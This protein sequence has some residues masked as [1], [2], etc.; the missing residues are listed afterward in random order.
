MNGW[1]LNRRTLVLAAM[2]AFL[3][4]CQVVPKAGP[5]PAPTV[6]NEPTAEALPTDDVR[7]RVAL[8]VP[9]TGSNGPVGQS[10]ANATTMALLDTNASGLRITTYDTATNAG[11]AASRA[12]QDGNMLILGPLMRENVGAV[13]A[14]ARSRSVPVISFSNDRSIA[15]NGVFVMGH[16][17]EQSIAR[18]V[19]FA[20]AK[21]ARTF[22]ALLP[23]GDYGERA[24]AALLQAVR[25][26]GGTVGTT[27]KY[28]R[29]N[30]SIV[31]A[32]QRLIAEGDADAVLVAEGVRLA[33]RAAGTLKNGDA[34]VQIIGTELWSGENS[35]ASAS[36]MSGAIFS[37]VSDAYYKGFADSYRARF[38]NAPY[39]I[40]TLGYDGVLLA[41][42]ISENWPKG[43]PF[44]VAQLLD[45]GGFLG[46]DGAFR[47][48][49]DGVIE[50]AMEVRQVGNATITVIDKA[51][52]TFSD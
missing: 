16:L 46:L 3:A 4:G 24:E 30:T 11:A 47:F 10:I 32:A 40:A 49:R 45:T 27:Q 22:S 12:I 52:G 48:G 42:N 35:L 33:V 37:S 31:S 51:P 28:A 2:G 23:Q 9:M 29:G 36:T 21:G 43:R 39:R 38:G 50:R 8:L 25:E 44:P 19:E 26:V 13:Q 15:G 41:L 18:S 6:V 34:D 17:P 1:I 20:R 14:A 5:A 7:H